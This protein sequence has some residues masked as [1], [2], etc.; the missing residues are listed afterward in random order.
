MSVDIESLR[1]I[2]TLRYNPNSKSK[3]L[4]IGYDDFL[5]KSRENDVLIVEN[6]LKN[7]I[8]NYI[9]SL[10]Q[11]R[12]T[13][14]LSSGIDSVL[15]LTLIRELFPELKITCIS[16]GFEENDEEVN[17]AKEISR[18]QNCDFKQIHLENFLNNLPK[19]ISIIKEPKWHY[20][21]YFLAEEAKNHS[22]VL[23]TGDGG[24][25]LFGG[26]VFRYENFLNSFYNKSTWIEK[27]KQYLNCHNRDWVQDQNQMFGTKVG[28]SWEKIYQN[29]QKYFDNSLTPIEQVFFADYAGKL[30]HDW[31]PALD[32]I[33]SHFG[34]IGISP[35][36]DDEII[37]FSC[38]ISP[39]KKYNLKTNQ[40]K[41]ILR[42]ISQNKKISIN[43]SKRGFS[44]DLISFWKN[45]G[46]KI[47]QIYLKN[48]HVSK[49]NYINESW[50]ITSIE[51]ANSND[52]RYINKLLSVLSFEI[53]YR[54]FITKEIDSDYT[55][56]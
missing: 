42:K 28:F 26:Y 54:L 8:S 48:S 40:G 31:V 47:T 9:K 41:L 36:L 45:Y 17:A 10:S 27:T 22:S 12:I 23:F 53:W 38:K 15:I 6:L 30:M 32:K 1:N 56:L 34:I 49:E 39:E 3:L 19:Q 25:E 55:L 5:L 33:H 18:I 43:N 16:A 46:N 21:W 4:K 37:K 2:L 14:A 13:L 20:Y 44:P 52:I 50:I 11:N 24:D 7:S 29:F 51:K 35:I